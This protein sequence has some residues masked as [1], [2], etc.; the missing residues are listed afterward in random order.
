MIRRRVTRRA[1][2]G[3][4]GL[5]AVAL[6][7]YGAGR[8]WTAG[9]QDVKD[10]EFAALPEPFKG[11]VDIYLD[12]SVAAAGQELSGRVSGVRILGYRE[13]AGRRFLLVSQPHPDKALLRKAA[14]PEL[15]KRFKDLKDAHWL[16]DPAHIVAVRSAEN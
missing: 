15:Y 3:C 2:F 10:K 16:L 8:A 11:E 1:F 5:L 4:L 13:F 14:N 12:A 9:G 6:T 7:L